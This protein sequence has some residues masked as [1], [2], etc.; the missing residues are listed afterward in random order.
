M[1]HFMN[2]YARKIYFGAKIQIF[3]R[4]CKMR[5]FMNFHPLCSLSFLCCASNQTSKS[6]SWMVDRSKGIE[7]FSSIKGR[8]KV[9]GCTFSEFLLLFSRIFA[10]I[11]A[12]ITSYLPIH[13][14]RYAQLTKKS[15]WKWLKSQWLKVTKKSHFY[16]SCKM[17]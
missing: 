17:S 8:T 6:N 15:V 5:L 12:I 4:S 11:N 10:V 2:F 13:S 14:F 16:L 9:N 7:K 3:N 1:S